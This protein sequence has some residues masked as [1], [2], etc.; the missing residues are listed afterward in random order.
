MAS[1]VVL[2]EILVNECALELVVEI[3]GLVG[4]ACFGVLRPSLEVMQRSKPDVR[5]LH[6]DFEDELLEHLTGLL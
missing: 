6:R 3:H 4:I 2:R 5:V 1:L